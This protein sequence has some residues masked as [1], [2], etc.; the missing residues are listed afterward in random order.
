ME[1]HIILFDGE[2]NFC[3]FWVKFVIKRDKKD[4]FRFA[5]LQSEIGE[6][7]LKKYQL[8]GDLDSVVFI[9]GNE[10]FTKSTASFQI[11]KAL[12]GIISIFYYL[13]FIPAI[14]RDFF[15]DVMAKYRYSLFGSKTC[16]IPQNKNY[17]HKF[18]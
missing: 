8:A 15:Y 5:S 13:I 11:L 14:I 4:L 18:L 3:S 1:K 6:K 2:C 10:V 9:S 7:L 16:E 17:A 12:G